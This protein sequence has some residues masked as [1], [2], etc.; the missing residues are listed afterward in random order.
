MAKQRTPVENAL[1]AAGEF[2]PIPPPLTA[3]AAWR[4][5]NP[6]VPGPTG[7]YDIATDSAGNPAAPGKGDYT[8]FTPGGRTAPGN[9][10]DID[11]AKV[12][13]GQ[14]N[15]PADLINQIETLGKK[16][17]TTNPDVFFQSALNAVRG[18]DWFAQT[19]PGFAAGVRAGLFQDESGYRGYVS[20][21]NT[22][23]QQYLG[24]HVSGDETAAALTQGATPGLIGNQFQG[25]TIA[26]VNASDWQYLSGAFDEKGPL[27]AAERTALGREQAGID[28]PLGQQIARR[29]DYAKQRMQTI[30]Q[31]RLATP[32]LTLGTSGLQ[33]PG[34]L[35]TRQTPDV[36]A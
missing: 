4:L 12:Y 31:G 11:W 6:T 17:G 14:Y 22:I 19:Y 26:N 13:F 21:L 2:I 34:M 23:Y 20:N 32:G 29:L 33:A 16:Y 3:Q 35:G 25:D 7:T 30:F 5:A 36:G 27:T 28:T 1:S 24:R 10:A 15:L 8:Q 9:G 18:S